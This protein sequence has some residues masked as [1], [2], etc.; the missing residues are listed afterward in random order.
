MAAAG[1][2]MALRQE[3][4]KGVEKSVWLVALFV[5][6]CV[7]FRAIDKDRADHDKE[8]AATRQKEQ[9]HFQGIVDGLVQ[10][11]QEVTGGDSYA[12]VSPV[13]LSVKGPNMFPLIAHMV[14]ENSLSD[15]HV[16]VRKLPIANEGTM[17]QAIEVLTGRGAPPV[18]VGPIDTDYVLQLNSTI[19]PAMTGTT[20]YVVNI[21]A[22]NKPTVETLKVRLNDQTKKWEYSYKV[23]RA[24]KRPAKPGDL[25][26]YKTLE[27]T[28]WITLEI[29]L[30]KPPK[31]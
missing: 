28:S 6:L 11:L 23:I 17:S 21:Y 24:A 10:N 29:I 5:F 18:Y 13:L 15:A 9:E 25:S 31:Q 1:T 8:Q 16:F 22:R 2:V 30:S 4:M 19:T 3:K 27:E 14:G 12:V 26:G 20:E 7:E